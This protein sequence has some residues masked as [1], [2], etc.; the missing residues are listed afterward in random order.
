MEKVYV[1]TDNSN[2]VVEVNSARFITDLTGWY[3]IDEGD[4]DKYSHAQA[5]YFDKPITTDD[6]IFRYRLVDGA[7]A[8]KTEEEIATEISAIPPPPLPTEKLLDLKIKAVSDYQDFLEECIVEMA[9]LV[10]AS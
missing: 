7:V 5:H 10:Y 6:G 2:V 4:G 3:L 1:R 9:G 8:E